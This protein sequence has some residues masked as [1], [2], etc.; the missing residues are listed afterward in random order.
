MTAKET[1][2]A[3]LAELPDSVTMPEIIEQLCLG[4]AIEEGLQDIAAGRFYTHE[5]VVAHFQFGVPL[6]DLSQGR[7]EPQPSGRV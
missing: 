5:E 7:P 4:M 3:T 6:P 1:A 2:M